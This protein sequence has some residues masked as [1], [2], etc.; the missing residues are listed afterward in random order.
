[1]LSKKV[2]FK[3]LYVNTVSKSG[4]FGY[5]SSCS[6][7]V[8]TESESGKNSMYGSGSGKYWNLSS[9]SGTNSCHESESNSLIMC[10]C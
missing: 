2:K 7:V 6:N 9:R 10:I 1:M 5:N 8:F 4:K 3:R